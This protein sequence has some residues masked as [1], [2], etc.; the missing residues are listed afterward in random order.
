MNKITV[1]GLNKERTA[2][3]DSLM[4]LG[5]VDIRQEEPNEEIRE[6]AHS[7]NVQAE[8]TKIDTQIADLNRALELLNRY[9]PVKK[10]LFSA[11]KIVTEDDYFSVM[12][13]SNEILGLAH[14]INHFE[15]E[16]SR[17]KGEE[18]RLSN[19]SQALIPWLELDIPLNILNTQHTFCML[20]SLSSTLDLDK[21]E[22]ELANTWSEAI[23]LRG[24]TEKEH[25]YI[26]IIAHN[27][28]EAE[29]MAFLRNY[30]WNRINLRDVEGTAKE[31][32]MLLE[33]KLTDLQQ[34]R[35]EKIAAIKALASERERLEV[36]SD[37]FR[38]ERARIE[39]RSLLVSTK[40]VF[41][42]KGWLPADVSEKVKDY[43]DKHF[44]CTVDIVAPEKDEAYPVM[45][46]NGPIVEAI[47]PIMEMYGLP[48]SSE[49]DPSPVMLPFYLF[50]FGLMLGDGG[51]GLLLALGTGFAL[52]KFRMEDGTRRFFKL[53]FLCGLSTIFAGFLFGSWFGI[54]SLT[55]YA[56]WIVP[57]Q[58]PELMMSWAILFGI[59]HMYVGLFMKAVNYIR[60]GKIWDAICDV[61]FV[62]ILFTGFVF[63]LLPFAPGIDHSNLDGFV[64]IGTYLFIAGVAL[65]LLTQGRHNKNL[66]GKIFGGVG[67]L[68]D[69][70]GFFGDC[71]SYSRLLALG[72]ASSI[73]ADII[74]TLSMALGDNVIMKVFAGGAVLII[75]HTINFAIN[76]LGAY[77]HSC[78]LQFLEFFGK[79]LE[80][81][82]EPFKPFKANTKYVIV[83]TEVSKFLNSGAKVRDIA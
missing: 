64:K 23:L 51:Y 12:R 43:L 2:L 34:S 4:G 44:F 41:V 21:V 11:R 37:G 78:R 31:S 54:A 74:N 32:K 16:L 61:F 53:L 29:V 30:G 8:L 76:A 50:F 40:S 47:S 10:P 3:L 33:S 81:G 48:S 7:P 77:V 58:T 39:A 1:L 82:G 55:K 52:K 83:K 73:I 49:L 79:F 72:L 63:I 38:M 28:G 62:Y 35:E 71:L 25:H 66:F 59:I 14:R 42:L 68:Y 24:K 56:L 9:V 45:L 19:L 26:A 67:K 75:G 18:N 80:G 22:Q 46:K 70:V 5:V 15:D 27:S 13:H 60:H 57:T 17:M 65:M 36:V 6:K 69:I 20:G